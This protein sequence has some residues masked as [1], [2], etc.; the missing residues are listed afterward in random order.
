ML[1]KGAQIDKIRNH[2]LGAKKCNCH[3]LALW[4]FFSFI[5]NHKYAWSFQSWCKCIISVMNIC[6][7]IC[8]DKNYSVMTFNYC[9]LWEILY[10]ISAGSIHLLLNKASLKP[11]LYL[12]TW[13]KLTGSHIICGH[14]FIID[15]DFH[16]HLTP[17]WFPSNCILSDF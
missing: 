7:N 4:F 3:L 17:V 11:S 1:V 10:H 13:Y 16:L 9:T 14:G 2:W 15:W 12:G 6:Q 5:L 8:H